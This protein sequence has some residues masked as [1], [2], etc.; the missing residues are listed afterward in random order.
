M[1]DRVESMD[2]TVSANDVQSPPMLRSLG[3]GSYGSV[4]LLADGTVG[5]CYL[6]EEEDEKGH[7]TKVT[8]PGRGLPRDGVKEIAL[9]SGL[10]NICV[11]SLIRALIDCRKQ[12]WCIMECADM[13][14]LRDYM[15]SLMSGP[16]PDKR[17]LSQIF[18][19]LAYIHSRNIIH[20]DVK[21]ENVLVFHRNPIRI[22]LADF[23]SALV[24]CNTTRRSNVSVDLRTDSITTLWYRA[25]EIAFGL[26]EMQ[27]FAMDVWA[28]GLISCEIC[29]LTRP[30]FKKAKDNSDLVDRM[31]GM[32][33][34]PTIENDLMPSY[35]KI[36][37]D[38]PPT[39]NA[40]TTCP[41][42]CDQGCMPRWADRVIRGCLS[43]ELTRRLSAN[44]CAD[45]LGCKDGD[46]DDMMKATSCPKTPRVSHGGDPI[47][48]I[49]GS[50]SH[51]RLMRS[52]AGNMMFE[53]CVCKRRG[54]SR[55]AFHAAIRLYDRVIAVA[56]VEDCKVPLLC[57]A[58]SSIASKLCDSYGIGP[59]RINYVKK[60]HVR[61]TNHPDV[62][63]LMPDAV[64]IE[65]IRVLELMSWEV[66]DVTVLDV[67]I[68]PP[69]PNIAVFNFIVDLMCAEICM[70]QHVPHDM[71]LV[72]NL[73]V[74]T[75]CH[76]GSVVR[77]FPSFLMSLLE[78]S[79]DAMN[80]TFSGNLVRRT[81]S[82]WCG[83]G[84]AGSNVWVDFDN[85][86][87]M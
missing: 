14:N 36:Y 35:S 53:L 77:Q 65:E 28:A 52:V 16:L 42:P 33:G 12:L 40:I 82:V 43:L 64:E 44:G 79:I 85:I 55:R 38:V 32:F 75:I 17:I 58:V 41:F 56:G 59:D 20:R 47:A 22:K 80:M 29:M 71:V 72:A 5:K 9:L 11:V 50:S 19:G 60:T 87:W 46:D 67:Q 84:I 4:F 2:V 74:D 26:H 34:I 15:G 3:S 18:R 69:H 10:R 48:D 39:K 27:T 73:I 51:S 63:D 24:H 70:D 6:D 68:P 31:C 1:S 54:G 66:W 49:V 30:L 61:L 23:G 7:K 37:G 86:Q 21:P 83:D 25:P 81:H 45:L 76:P 13:G 8:R 57:A 62:S 78:T